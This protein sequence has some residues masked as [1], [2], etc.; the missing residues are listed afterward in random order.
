M[1]ENRKG[2]T[3]ILRQGGIF[4]ITLIPNVSK[5]PKFLA[6]AQTPSNTRLTVSKTKAW[7]T[8]LR[9]DACSLMDPSLCWTP[10]NTLGGFKEIERLRSTKENFVIYKLYQGSRA[11]IF[12][13]CKGLQGC[14]GSQGFRFFSPLGLAAHVGL[15]QSWLSSAAWRTEAARAQRNPH[16]LK[17]CLFEMQNW[18]MFTVLQRL[19]KPIQ[20]GCK[21]HQQL[22]CIL[23]KR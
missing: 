10:K 14:Q 21:R 13:T 23:G 18:Q 1:Q 12:Q 7:L 5:P 15:G 4:I 19:S 22:R 11:I 6:S 17:C 20:S 9:A 2:P 16:S 3:R 8:K